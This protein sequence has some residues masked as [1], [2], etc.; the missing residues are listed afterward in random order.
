MKERQPI[1]FGL[2]SNV[3][4]REGFLARALAMLA[5]EFG[6]LAHSPLYESAA[7][8]LPGAPKGPAQP[9]LNMAACGE[10]DEGPVQVLA[11]AKL[12]EQQLGRQDRGRWA[13][14]EVDIDIL[15][16]GGMVLKS[17]TLIIPHA[18]LLRRDF[19]L[20][21]LSEVAPGWRYPAQGVMQGKTARDMVKALN[22]AEHAGLKRVSA[23]PGAP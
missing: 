4:D 11:I 1:I 5:A 13:P 21:P 2:G 9:Y 7:L 16:Y 14:R 10:T 22:M 8:I 19:A 20:L 3:G 23:A 15:A 6:P 18:E 12:I 17:R